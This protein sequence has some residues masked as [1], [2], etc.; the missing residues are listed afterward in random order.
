M[1]RLVSAIALLAAAGLASAEH[2][3]GVYIPLGIMGYDYDDSVRHLDTNYMPTV[4]VGYRFNDGWAAEVMAAK[5]STDLDSS[6]LNPFNLSADVLHYRLDGLYYFGSGD[7]TPYVVAG[8]G[9]TRIDYDV[10]GDKNNTLMDAGIGLQYQVSEGLALRGD[11][12]ALHSLD[13]DYTEA[14]FNL[15]VQMSFGDSSKPAAAAAPV[16]AA[17]VV[18][19]DNDG[20]GVANSIDQCPSTPAGK[21]VDSVG[22]DCNYTLNLHFEFDSAVLT[23]EDRAELDRLA[24]GIQHLNHTRA[25][26]AGYTDSKGSEAYN[27]QLSDRRANAVMTYLG[28]KGIDT[29]NFHAVGYGESNPVADNATD[30]GRALNR[31]VVI[32]RTDCGTK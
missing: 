29:A 7:L 5:G 20:D 11:V 24:A 19:N 26:V 18:N 28:S 17:S 32:S 15:L 22:C 6:L 10:F 30:A 13:N 1:K 31:R 23:A 25:E 9:E 27:M 21:T 4:G 14:A 3:E 2:N 12:R 8:I 16:A